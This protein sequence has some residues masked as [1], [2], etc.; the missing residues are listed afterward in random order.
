MLY[1]V[2]LQAVLLFGAET[3][4]LLGGGVQEA[5]GCTCGFSRTGDGSDGQ[6]A[7][8]RDL[9]KRGSGKGTQRSCNTDTRGV[10]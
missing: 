5:G 7:E 6:A 2:V 1:R 10:H 8:D 4:I 3:W 9:Q